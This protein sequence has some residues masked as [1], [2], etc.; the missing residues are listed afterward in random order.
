MWQF[1]N[2]WKNNFLAGAVIFDYPVDPRDVVADFGVDSWEILVGTTDAPGHD[3]LKITITDKRPAR[4]ALQPN[5]AQCHQVLYD[6]FCLIK[7][8]FC[9]YIVSFPLCVSE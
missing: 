9:M 3:P 6:T 2:L 8:V 7:N 5:K 4:V 1:N